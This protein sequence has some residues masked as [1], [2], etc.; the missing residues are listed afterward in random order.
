MLKLMRL[1]I[2]TL[3]Y[4]KKNIMMNLSNS[5]AAIWNTVTASPPLSIYM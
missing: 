3:E 4:M 5:T 1:I 2:M